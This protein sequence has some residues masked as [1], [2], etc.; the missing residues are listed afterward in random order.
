MEDIAVNDFDGDQIV[1]TNATPD[2]SNGHVIAWIDVIP[3]NDSPPS[4]IGLTPEDCERVQ[5]W[6]KARRKEM[7]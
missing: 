5:K 4:T 7:A 3:A 1:L 2:E 6:L